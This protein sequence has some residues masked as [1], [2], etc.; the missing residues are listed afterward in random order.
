M[1]VDTRERHQVPWNDVVAYR[2]EDHRVEQVCHCHRFDIAR[3]EIAMWKMIV[4]VTGHR[5]AYRADDEFARRAARCPDA[6]LYSAADP[7]EMYGTGVYF[8]PGTD[9]TDLR[10]AN[11]FFAQ[12]RAA[13]H[14]VT[15]DFVVCVLV[16]DVEEGLH[17]IRL[18]I[19]EAQFS[20]TFTCN[21]LLTSLYLN[22]HPSRYP[23]T[24]PIYPVD[25]PPPMSVYIMF[26]ILRKLHSWIC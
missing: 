4:V 24:L 9:D 22:I 6:V 17:D 18:I 8:A 7:V 23:N 11:A 10:P 14:L 16:N 26:L 15:L 13:Q 3:N 5:G 2:Y 20:Q 1:Q 21:V 19:M 12:P 25:P